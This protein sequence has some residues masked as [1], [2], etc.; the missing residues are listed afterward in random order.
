MTTTLDDWQLTDEE[1]NQLKDILCA[2][3]RAAATGNRGRRRLANDR[4]VAEAC[5][6]RHFHT[7]AVRYRSFG[8]HKLPA[9]LGVS[10]ATANR[11][12][13][14]WTASGA[15]LRFWDALTKLR[16]LDAPPRAPGPRRAGGR[17]FPVQQI[18]AALEH[19][20]GFLNEQL[21]G[22]TL[23]SPVAITLET[24]RKAMAGYFCSRL[25]QT[26]DRTMGQIAVCTSLLGT[27]SELV[28]ATLLHEMVHLRN[29]QFGLADCHPKNQYHSRNFRDVAVLHGLQ[30]EDRDPR[31]GYARTSLDERGH[32]AIKHLALDEQLFRWVVKAAGTRFGSQ[33]CAAA[34]SRLRL[35]A[36]A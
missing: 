1:W 15:W 4:R 7:L 23:A 13:R 36:P 16:Q 22:N 26:E 18:I 24:P 27:G 12:F 34:E 21:F 28:L 8:W 35:A 29:D 6:F 17:G 32:Q 2:A 25:W 3:P 20:Y 33:G 14:E 9:T 31:R 5:L 19:A 11:R 10:P 30:C